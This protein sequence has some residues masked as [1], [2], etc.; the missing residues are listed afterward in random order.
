M[1][2]K[3]KYHITQW[4]LSKECISKGDKLAYFC[5]KEKK[6]IQVEY[7]DHVPTQPYLM[8]KRL[9]KDIFEAINFSTTVVYKINESSQYFKE[10]L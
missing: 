8:G 3:N 2:L 10:D 1:P 6:E 5:E 9:D 4:V 7:I